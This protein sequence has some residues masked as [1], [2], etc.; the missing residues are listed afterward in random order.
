M[1]WGNAWISDADPTTDPVATVQSKNVSH[2]EASLS[3]RMDKMEALLKLLPGV[4][5]P[6]FKRA[7]NC[8]TYSLFT[9]KIALV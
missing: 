9:D 4:I 2:L 7:P 6:I 1:F 5:T 8:Y 3:K